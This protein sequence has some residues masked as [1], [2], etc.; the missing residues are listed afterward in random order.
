MYGRFSNTWAVVVWAG[1]FFRSMFMPVTPRNLR[2]SVIKKHSNL[3]ITANMSIGEVFLGMLGKLV[4]WGCI[5]IVRLRMAGGLVVY[6]TSGT[7]VV[8]RAVAVIGATLRAY[9]FLVVG[10]RKGDLGVLV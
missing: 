3:S 4:V 2:L 8:R 6:V 1:A 5:P 10:C 9:G 7:C